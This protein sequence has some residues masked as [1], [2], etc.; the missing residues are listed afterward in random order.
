MLFN[1]TR[2]HLY[3]RNITILVPVTWSR[4]S[5]YD[6]A[7]LEAYENAHFRVDHSVDKEH[8]VIPSHCGSEGQ[9]VAL[10][11]TFVLDKDY[12]VSVHGKTGNALYRK[13]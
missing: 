5:H 4:R 11:Q 12:R 7:L 6:Y 2:Y 13:I 3:W 10:S 8:K 1:A 9:H